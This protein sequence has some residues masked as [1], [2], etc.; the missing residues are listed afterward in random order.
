MRR[1]LEN[2]MI[3]IVAKPDL[4]EA[5][6]QTPLTRVEVDVGVKRTYSVRA[7]V[8]PRRCRI[9]DSPIWR[10]DNQRC[11][12][13]RNPCG[14]SVEPDRVVGAGIASSCRAVLELSGARFLL[15]G[16]DFRF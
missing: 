12:A 5:V 15:T 4:R 1:C 13:A 14:S 16:G 11:A 2:L 8:L 7:F 6:T 10:I 9:G 3:W